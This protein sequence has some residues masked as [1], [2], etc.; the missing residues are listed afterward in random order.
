MS[1]SQ[2]QHSLY[3]CYFG[4]HK[5]LVQTQVLPYLRQISNGGVRVSL[6][7]FEP[8][9]SE[10]WA[11]EQIA[12]ER[13][14]LSD[15]G[16]E[17]HFLTYHKRPSLPATLYDVLCGAWFS[18]KLARKE[19]IN[20]IH[21][22]THIPLLMALIIKFA[23]KSRIIFDIRGL[24]A[25]EYADSGIW[26]ENS[27]AFRLVKKLERLGLKHAEQVV[28]LTDK[29]RNYLVRHNL[30]Q[31]DSIEVIPCCVDFSRINLQAT[32][33]K[34]ARFELIYAGSVTGLYMLE[35]MGRLFLEL[36]K[37]K[38]DA[39][40]RILTTASPDVVSETFKPLGIDSTDYLVQKV[41]PREVLNYL[42]KAHLAI[43]FRQPTFSQI[44][45]S[46]TKVPEYLAAGVPVISNRGIGDTDL[47]IEKNRVGVL[48]DNFDGED[49]AEAVDKSL[50][51]L[52]DI[53]LLER[54]LQTALENFD[55]KKI[56][57]VRYLRVYERLSQDSQGLK[58]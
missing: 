22:R 38:P 50:I 43:S 49:L 53:K 34:S 27:T 11:E 21:A 19:K 13:R 31:A 24:L 23:T 15:E 3:I 7:T 5:P 30:R 2:T 40:F 39:F 8:N 20:I 54:C 29:M 33:K 47:L 1:V 6:L 52:N 55:L 25:D 9:P 51:L 26:Q 35:E 10:K 41:S 36:K 58:A 14:K 18:L 4:L 44:A 17:W 42:Q 56:G 37:R 57:G 32:V 16:I 28:V 48:T 45:A 12:E 46:P